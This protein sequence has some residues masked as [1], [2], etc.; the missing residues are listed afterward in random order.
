[1]QQP[2]SNLES[3]ERLSCMETLDKYEIICR[4]LVAKQELNY[5]L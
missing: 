3:L 4:H 1:L 2:E 5:L